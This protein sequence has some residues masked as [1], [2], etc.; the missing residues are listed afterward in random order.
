MRRSLRV[1]ARAIRNTEAIGTVTEREMPQSSATR[2]TPA[3]S[4]NS[5]TSVSMA[6]GHDLIVVVTPVTTTMAD[7]ALKVVIVQTS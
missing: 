6:A 5:A 1:N 7:V 2:A 4:A 3:N